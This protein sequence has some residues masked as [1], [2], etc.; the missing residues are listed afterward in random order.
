MAAFRRPRVAR[1]RRLC[2]P[3]APAS[4]ATSPF[5]NERRVLQ[6]RRLMLAQTWLARPCTQLSNVA[7]ARGLPALDRIRT[8]KQSKLR[9][10]PNRTKGDGPEAESAA[11]KGSYSSPRSE[12]EK[13]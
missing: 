6:F 8:D 2:L 5:L 3:R 7:F 12:N 11:S 9:L 13:A 4:T 10:S 1:D